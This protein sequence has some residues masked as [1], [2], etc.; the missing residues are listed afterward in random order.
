M[1][2]PMLKRG[3]P[4]RI[5]TMS[6]VLIETEVLRQTPMHLLASTVWSHGSTPTSS[7]GLVRSQRTALLRVPCTLVLK[8]AKTCSIRLM[9]TSPHSPARCKQ[10]CSWIRGYSSWTADSSQA[11]KPTKGATERRHRK[12]GIPAS[13]LA[14]YSFF[15]WKYMIADA[16]IST[17]PKTRNNQPHRDSG[18]SILSPL[19]F[20]P[21]NL[22]R[23]SI[24]FENLELKFT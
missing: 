24:R 6:S 20:P 15:F 3:S 8:A 13:Q 16:V 9:Q 19:N 5:N 11:S 23:A 17:A 22:S 21:D 10:T 12:S 14:L 1:H 2:F 7:T 18:E 4:K